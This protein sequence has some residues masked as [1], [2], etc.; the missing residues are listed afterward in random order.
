MP[1]CTN[2]L[3]AKFHGLSLCTYNCFSY[4]TH[5]W[6]S[7]KD[8]YGLLW[9][10]HQYPPTSL[11]KIIKLF[12]NQILFILLQWEASSFSNPCQTRHC[13]SSSF[14]GLFALALSDNRTRWFVEVQDGSSLWHLLP[15]CHFP[16]GCRTVLRAQYYTV[17]TSLNQLVA[18]PSLRA[19]SNCSPTLFSGAEVHR[20]T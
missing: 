2:E 5:L 18:P 6:A 15:D 9:I 20:G 17:P 13:H 7:V 1:V 19:V 4:S 8:F 14:W 12:F 3:L 16:R 10:W 11:S